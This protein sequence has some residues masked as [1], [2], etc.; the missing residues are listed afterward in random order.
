MHLVL[1]KNVFHLTLS[2]FTLMKYAFDRSVCIA[3]HE[4]TF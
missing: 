3:L 2:I 4:S 1:K